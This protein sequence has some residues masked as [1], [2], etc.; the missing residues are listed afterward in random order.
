M[1]VY[2]QY[3][4]PDALLLNAPHLHNVPLQIAAERGLPALGF[5]IWAIGAIVAAPRR[6]FAAPRVKVPSVFSPRPPWPR[7]CRCSAPACSSTTS[8]IPSS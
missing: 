8:A 6:C 5:W 7:W 3:R 4:D 1:R 2:A